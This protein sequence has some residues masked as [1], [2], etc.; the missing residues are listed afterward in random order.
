M[1]S[2]CRL[3]AVLLAAATLMP[4][5]A[6]AQ[7]FPAKP[8]RIIVPYPPGGALDVTARSIAN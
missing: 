4:L 1:K 2:C 8:V 6:A 7:A 3:A 5:T